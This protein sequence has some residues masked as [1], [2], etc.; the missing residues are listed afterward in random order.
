MR[1]SRTESNLVVIWI[2]PNSR[3]RAIYRYP[4][5]MQTD[6]FVVFLYVNFRDSMKHTHKC[7]PS[8]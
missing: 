1:Q 4:F 5:Q 3:R 6:V 7:P 2:F 8:L